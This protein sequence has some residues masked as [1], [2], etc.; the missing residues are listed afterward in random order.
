MYRLLKPVNSSNGKGKNKMKNI[1]KGIIPALLLVTMATPGLAEN[2]QG[3]VT[4]SP[5]VGGYLLDH[6]QREANRPIFGLRGGYNFTKNLGA[7]AM[8]GYSLTKTKQGNRETDMYRYGV[9][10]LYHFMPDSNF[11]PFVAIGGGGTSFN[12]PNTPSAPSHYAGLFSYGG[13]VK[14][15][16]SDNVA[17]RGDVRHVVLHHDT[18]DNNLEYSAGL[19][20]QFGGVQKAATALPPVEKASTKNEQ[21][22]DTT[23]PTVLFTAPVNGAT[24]APVNQKVNAAFSEAM[25]PA[26]INSTTFT[27][28]QGTVPVT[29]AVT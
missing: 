9:D 6:E 16:V 15:F 26:T 20:F 21:V 3:A 13:G 8:F 14:Y 27:L 18:G 22:A 19:T 2:R 12:T 29:G 11:V 1:L 17:L 24:A 28:N 23:E 25:D 5:F 7:E 10:V 4:V